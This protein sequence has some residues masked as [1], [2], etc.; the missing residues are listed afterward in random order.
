MQADTRVA[1]RAPAR[2][3][4]RAVS[5]VNLQLAADLVTTLDGR[6]SKEA[7]IRIRVSALWP[8]SRP[9][10]DSRVVVVPDQ[11]KKARIAAE[12]QRGLTSLTSIHATVG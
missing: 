2:R 7:G 10:K 9:G 12:K 1:R 6:S 5:A 8:C 11:W 4:E 3:A